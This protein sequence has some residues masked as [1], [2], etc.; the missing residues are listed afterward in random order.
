MDRS[1]KLKLGSCVY[2]PAISISSGKT[3]A[4]SY[5]QNFERDGRVTVTSSVEKDSNSVSRHGAG[6]FSQLIWLTRDGAGRLLRM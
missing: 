4:R 1:Q 2:N 6:L 5:S 3:G